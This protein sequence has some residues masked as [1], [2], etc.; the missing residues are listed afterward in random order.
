M[1]LERKRALSITCF[2]HVLLLLYC[3]ALPNGL[4]AQTQQSEP[5][6]CAKPFTNQVK[7]Y[8]AT[9][10]T[11]RI[12]A[13]YLRDLTWET[14][15]IPYVIDP[16]MSAE[17]KQ[18]VREAAVEFSEK[19]PVTL[20]E[21]DHKFA[22]E[23][24]EIR[25][26][27]YITDIQKGDV[28]GRCF[29]NQ[30]GQGGGV[31]IKLEMWKYGLRAK[32]PLKGSIFSINCRT[33]SEILHEFGHVI[34]LMHEQWHP[35]FGNFTEFNG[36]TRECFRVYQWPVENLLSFPKQ[37]FTNSWTETYN[38]TS[39]MHWAPVFCFDR[40]LDFR[41]NEVGRR[42][43]LNGDFLCGYR[44]SELDVSECFRHEDHSDYQIGIS[45]CISI[46][47]QERVMMLY[48]RVDEDKFGIANLNS[49]DQCTS[50]KRLL[51]Q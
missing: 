8:L 36:N 21:C 26:F 3:L 34:G 48:E 13:F 41:F 17:W 47:D 12:D 2:M 7:S 19:L 15:T 16:S 31:S 44:S 42:M 37:L 4:L 6:F 11:K 14:K 46:F 50:P 30:A 43:Y 40:K 32:Y 49:P 22:A 29:V 39:I 10:A 25:S 9:V 45:E 51:A 33:Y 27:T 24:S 18:K 35:R 5:K 20:V 28:K 38:P 1:T 23:K